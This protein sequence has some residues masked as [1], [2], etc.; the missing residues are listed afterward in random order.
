MGQMADLTHAN[1]KEETLITKEVSEL[2]HI[3][4]IIGIIMGL[5]CFVLAFFLGY[6]W[7]DAILFLIG[8]IVANIPESLLA[9]FTISLSVSTSRLSKR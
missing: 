1:P 3:L 4:T 5:F 9:V 7:I 8:V 2:M 6:F